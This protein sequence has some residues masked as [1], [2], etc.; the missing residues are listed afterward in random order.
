MKLTVAQYYEIVQCDLSDGSYILVLISVC[1]FFM[2]VFFFF[3]FFCFFNNKG[4][5]KKQGLDL[6]F[7][8]TGQGY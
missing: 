4:L 3:V 5:G 8:P 6:Q 2:C 7:C 1:V